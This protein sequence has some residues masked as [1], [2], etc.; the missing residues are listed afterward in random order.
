[1][2]QTFNSLVTFL[3]SDPLWKD[4]KPGYSQ[5]ISRHMQSWQH[6]IAATGGYI[7]ANITMTGTIE[8]LNEWYVN[9]LG[10]HIVI[11]DHTLTTV[12]E[13][14][15]N[16]LIYN[17]G[18]QSFIFGP[19]SQVANR[20]KLIYTPFTD[21]TVSPPTTGAQ[22]ETT[23]AEDLP[24][25]ALWGIRE[26]IITEGN[27]IVPATIGGG[28]A[29]QATQ[30]RDAKLEYLKSPERSQEIQY[31]GS[32]SPSIVLECL[33]Y[34][35]MLDMYTHTSAAAGF[36]TY[37][38]KVKAIIAS[39]PNSLF[40]SDQSL[41]ETNALL[42]KALDRDR[43]AT[44]I[45]NEIAGWGGASNE[46][47][48]WGVTSDRKFYYMDAPALY[49]YIYSHGILY[50]YN[51]SRLHPWQVQAGRWIFYADKAGAGS[52][53]GTTRDVDPQS[54]LYGFIE[55]VA[56][57]SPYQVQISGRRIATKD[58]AQQWLTTKIL[59]TMRI[60]MEA[61]G[62]GVGG[63]H[64]LLGGLQGGALGDYYH[65]SLA[66]YGALHSAVTVLDSLSVDFTLVGQQITASVIPGGIDHGALAG[67][68]DDDHLQYVYMT[69]GTS[70]RNVIQPSGNFI[71]LSLKNN[72]GQLVDIFQALSSG[73]AILAGINNAGGI[74]AD[75]G[76]DTTN[77]YLGKGAGNSTV[78]A[79][80]HNIAVGGAGCLNSIGAGSIYNVALGNYA[81]D[82]LTTS[83]I[84][85]MAI[86]YEAMTNLTSSCSDNVAIGF[87]ALK[88]NGAQSNIAS[89][90]AIGTGA[91]QLIAGPNGRRNVAIGTYALN[92]AAI[93]QNA[94]AIGF[95]SGYSYTNSNGAIFIGANAGYN[96]T[97][98]RILMFDSV[99]AARA[100]A[101]LELTE[102]IVYGVMS[103]TLASQTLRF[104]AGV[105]VGFG[106]VATN[107]TA[108][109][110]TILHNS[111][112]AVANG[113]GSRVLYQL[114][115]STTE[116]QN[117]AAL[118]VIWIDATHASRVSAQVFY[119]YDSAGQIEAMRLVANST[120]V[121][122]NESGLD[123]DTRIEG[124]GDANLV[125]VDAGNNRVGIGVAAPLAKLDV[126]GTA[127]IGD[128]TTNYSGFEADGTLVFTGTATVFNDANVGAL[129]LQTGGTLPGIVEWLDNTGAASGIE[130]RGFA[131]GERGSGSI[132]IPHD[133]KEGTNLVFHIHWGA[134]DAPTGTDYVNW[135][136]T[137]SITRG[138]TT[139]P[140][141]TTIA[142]EDPYDTQ[143]ELKRTDFAAING[144]ALKIGD[145]FNFKIK[146]IAAVGD[147]FAGE[148]L[149]E[150]LGFHYEC[151]TVGSRTISS[152]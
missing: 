52:S 9:G 83:S 137:Y 28:G 87:R 91:L 107:A 45:L 39:D 59:K 140:P 114:E 97:S 119:V 41:I 98:G 104:N 127:R 56:F 12:W 15:V 17:Y 150:T 42:T 2:T 118:D 31:G 93:T 36:L 5:N 13:G 73:G 142:K 135:Q 145:Q 101:A 24:S 34:S 113:F 70:V 90:L 105:T 58:A 152:K 16:R 22:T 72:A 128:S 35:G 57:T 149:V 99:D 121:I 138:E 123:R 4:P 81:C 146:R 108:T 76:S 141:S 1:M 124:S 11:K 10:R 30:T 54:A 50:D 133:Y 100:S 94:V 33:G 92:N 26:A 120:G 80:S 125:F 69:P 49:D 68:G 65:L 102:A 86:G 19:L 96:Q 67:L 77:L 110:L 79:A 64:N 43:T 66:Q 55:H 61:G 25:Q 109:P 75:K 132:E 112:G 115:S 27:L 84:E 89:N 62:G 143:Y 18:E 60:N 23:Y 6:E 20:V 32:V 116:N 129:V 147:A 51:H 117:A 126:V 40:N 88:G 29:D 136:L 103:T 85:N 122:I 95:Y 106:S 82:S 53:I 7:S 3:A 71:A 63:V 130:T 74:Y 131:I 139:F 144:A 44:E 148:A 8:F 48:M 47:W 21:I 46:H 78:V 37:T 38:N 14:Y 134:N 111:T 151:D